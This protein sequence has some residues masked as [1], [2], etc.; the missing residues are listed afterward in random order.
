VV[1]FLLEVHL[2][3]TFFSRFGFDFCS[4]SML[5][6]RPCPPTLLVLLCPPYESFVPMSSTSQLSFVIKFLSE[7]NPPTV[8]LLVS[9]LLEALSPDSARGFLWQ[10]P[11]RCL[12]TATNAST[13][14]RN[15]ILLRRYFHKN[16]LN[17]RFPQL[18]NQKE[19][20][21]P[22]FCSR[23]ATLVPYFCSRWQP[24]SHTF[25]RGGN[26]GPVLL[27]EVQP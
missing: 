23:G 24:S 10:L 17:F 2:I 4:R 7:P 16:Q 13:L 3:C 9:P 25:A 19:P 26:P 27:L 18:R 1:A 5:F 22:Y 12:R 8:P 20:L 14:L 11:L 15:L 21:V 6:S